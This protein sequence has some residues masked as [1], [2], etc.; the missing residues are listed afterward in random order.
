MPLTLVCVRTVGGAV[1]Y[2]RRNPQF[3]EM[4]AVFSHFVISELP[5]GEFA[6]QRKSRITPNFEG[7]IIVTR[8]HWV[9][10]RTHTTGP[11]GQDWQSRNAQP[12]SD[13]PERFVRR[14]PT[15]GRGGGIPLTTE[16]AD[17]EPC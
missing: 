5:K 15:T 9:G 13:V 12:G 11:V 6:N 7:M 1:C 17:P 4:G 3:P 14:V 10:S 8:D 2:A 16:F